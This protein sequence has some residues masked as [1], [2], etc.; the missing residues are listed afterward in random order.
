MAR[1]IMV[2]RSRQPHALGLSSCRDMSGQEIFGMVLQV[3]QIDNH[4]LIDAFH[5]W[6]FMEISKR[7]DIQGIL[8]I[9]CPGCSP[10]PFSIHLDSNMK[11]F[12]WQPRAKSTQEPQLSGILIQ[13][14]D[15]VIDHLKWLDLAAGPGL[16]VRSL[17]AHQLGP[18][19]HTPLQAGAWK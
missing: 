14:T 16:Q 1:G 4:M 6:Q 8:D 13:P 2:M 7:K 17:L 10:S 19:W 12:T 3:T 5:E 11:L 9:E 15:Q 18:P